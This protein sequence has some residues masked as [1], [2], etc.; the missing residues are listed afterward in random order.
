MTNLHVV[1]EPIPELTPDTLYPLVLEALRLWHDT[2]S[3]NPLSAL[4]IWRA[5]PHTEKE[6]V[7]K[8]VNR[9]LLNAL[10]AL[11]VTNAD[12][13]HLLRKRFLDG[14]TGDE[15]ANRF[16]L[17]S[18]AFS[19]KQKEAVLALA[20]LL[21]EQEQ[22][23]QA[24]LR[25]TF[26]ARLAPPSYEQLFGVAHALSAL[27][28]I[29]N[30]PTAP[31]IIALEGMGGIG[32]TALADAVL[33]QA[34]TQTFY[35][36]FGWVS[37]RQQR[38]HP[39]G[40][41][42]TLDKPALTAEELIEQ[43]CT[44]L[45]TEVMLPQPFALKTALPILTARL[46]SAPYLIAIDNLETVTD[47]HEL[48][49]TLQLL[50]HP[51]RFLVTS[52][53]HLQAETATYT[54]AVPPL[55]ATDALA[56]VR[57][58]AHLRN[59]PDLAT[60]SDSQLQA[61]YTTVGGNPLALRL[62]VGQTQ[63]HDLPTVLADLQGA[64]GQAVENLYNYIYRYAWDNLDDLAR[65]V[66]LAMPFMPEQGEGVAHLIGICQLDAPELHDALAQL[67]ALN[68]VHHQRSLM[69]SRYTIHS[70]TRTFLLKQVAKWM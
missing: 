38:L 32:K 12:L 31:W 56:L 16:A 44:Q 13:A 54:Y 40:F 25:T 19:R 45:L 49:P 20:Y 36:G 50:S 62:V 70:L 29:L 15:T 28:N 4:F 61:I 21:C 1:Q 60:A 64:R 48:L 39:S 68:L 43:L 2:G 69:S 66:L 33:R 9:L 57:H 35:T 51:T 26:T 41:I 14:M 22:R 58:E 27:T 8:G 55:Q 17:S 23:L 63:L 7:R 52:R 67:A 42:Q 3:A 30:T 11:E 53:A 47:L 59:L 18:S 34:I 46:K 5:T 6:S 65:R 37:A 10:E 24:Q